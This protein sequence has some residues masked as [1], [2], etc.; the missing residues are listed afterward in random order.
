MGVPGGHTWSLPRGSLRAG[1][2][3]RVDR[4]AIQTLSHPVHTTG[5]STPVAGRLRLVSCSFLARN[6]VD[7]I[8]C[9]RTCLVGVLHALSHL[10]LPMSLFSDEILKIFFIAVRYTQHKM[11]HF[12]HFQVYNSVRFKYLQCRAMLPLSISRTFPSSQSETLYPLNTESPCPLP[13]SLW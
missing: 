1:V 6:R 7:Y 4:K 5:L 3:W 2:Q 10:T 9:Q 11:Y 8:F 12:N 13:S